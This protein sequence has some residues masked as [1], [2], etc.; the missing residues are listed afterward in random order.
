MLPALAVWAVA[1]L[2][3]GSVAALAVPVR[4]LACLA[5]A[6]YGIGYGLIEVSGLAWPPAPGRRWQVP[7]G[8]VIATGDRRRLLIWGAVL[9][10]G[11][12]TRNPYAAFGLLPLLVLGAGDVIEAMVLAALIGVAHG[13]GRA[14]ALLRD[15]RAPAPDPFALLLRSVRWRVTDGFALLVAAGAALV[16]GGHVLR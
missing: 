7:Q 10:P 12:L 5:A 3:L 8:L 1:G 13:A 4:A 2:V 9:G 6:V 14:A 11:W 16:V 15:A